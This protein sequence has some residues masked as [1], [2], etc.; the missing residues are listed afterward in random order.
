MPDRTVRNKKATARLGFLPEDEEVLL[1]NN[2]D[3]LG[4]DNISISVSSV[5]RPR[6]R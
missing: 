6:V 3:P 1:M 5:M 4:D 2:I